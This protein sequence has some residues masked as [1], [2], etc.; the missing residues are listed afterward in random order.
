MMPATMFDDTVRH[1]MVK[2]LSQL[3][4]ADAIGIAC[5]FLFVCSN[6]NPA[7]LRRVVNEPVVREGFTGSS[8]LTVLNRLSKE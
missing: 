3:P 6:K 5:S 7:L 1:Q 2:A 4:Q 8:L